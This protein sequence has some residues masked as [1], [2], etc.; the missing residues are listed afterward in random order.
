MKKASDL[1]CV[2]SHPD[3]KRAYV[4]HLFDRVAPRY[5]RF[6]RW[7]SYG[8][9]GGWKRELV[10]LIS[11]GLPD[12]SLVLDLACGTGDLGRALVAVRPGSSL[13]GLDLSWPMLQANRRNSLPRRVDTC[14]GDMIHLPFRDASLDAVLAGYAIRSSPDCRL[15]L[16]ELGRVLKPGGWLATLDFYQPRSRLRRTAFL[17]YLAAAGNLYGWL[18]HRSPGSY[19]YIARSLRLWL[20]A[21]AFSGFLQEHGFAV[22]EVK[23][24]LGGGIAIH[25]ARKR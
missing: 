11:D 6:T 4:R 3:R 14:Q 2:L 20:T 5:D 9:D 22:R 18:W 24:K 23:Q 1:P 7:F 12:D 16:V 15:A 25:L 13:I 10:A 21:G 17:A 8:M 19:G